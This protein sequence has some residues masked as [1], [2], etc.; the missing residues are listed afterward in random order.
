MISFFRPVDICLGDAHGLV[1][2]SL[3]PKNARERDTRR[4][5]LVELVPNNV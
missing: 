1:G 4:N 3:E 5:A 2:K